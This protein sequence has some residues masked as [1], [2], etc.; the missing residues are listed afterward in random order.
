MTPSGGQNPGIYRI[1]RDVLKRQ[2]EIVTIQ[3]EPDAIQ[4]RYLSA[5][6]DPNRVSPP[7]GPAPPTVEV[8]WKT[9]TPHDEFRIDYADPN[10][11]FHCGWH[12]DEDHSDLGGAHFQYET[13]PMDGPAHELVKFEA[14][15]PSRLLWE[16]LDRLFESAIPHYSDLGDRSG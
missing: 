15:S 10:L 3:Y 8:R 11:D 13:G 6:V 5:S 16:C 4:K 2:P 7:T 14:E 12:Q 1:L 9:S